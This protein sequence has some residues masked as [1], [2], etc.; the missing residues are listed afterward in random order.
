MPNAVESSNY[1]KIEYIYTEK[2]KKDVL[3][4]IKLR[5]NGAISGVLREYKNKFL[6]EN[7]NLLSKILGEPQENF[8]FEY[9]DRNGD[10]KVFNNLTPIEFKNKFHGII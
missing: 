7:Y 9:K 1:Q 5:E 6:Q 2:V 3:E 8:K 4:L 10:Y